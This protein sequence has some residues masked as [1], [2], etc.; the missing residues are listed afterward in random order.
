MQGLGA[1]IH[2]PEDV[3]GRHG[4]CLKGDHVRPDPWNH[5]YHYRNPSSRAGHDDDRCSA[6]PPGQAAAN[7]IRNR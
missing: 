6:G 2:Q 1:L 7:P 3:N 4:P 5:P